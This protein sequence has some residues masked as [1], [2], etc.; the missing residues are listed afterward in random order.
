MVARCTAHVVSAAGSRKRGFDGDDNIVQ[1]AQ[2]AKGEAEAGQILSRHFR[3]DSRSVP[4]DSLHLRPISPHA[5]YFPLLRLCDL[6]D[7]RDDRRMARS[8]LPRLLQPARA[9]IP[10]WIRLDSLFRLPQLV[11]DRRQRRTELA[12]SQH[13]PWYASS[14]KFVERERNEVDWNSERHRIEQRWGLERVDE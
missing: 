6:D 3:H 10:N 11:Y 9:G 7:S 4:V 12:Q 8:I 1:S 13:G 5:R 2:A 14:R